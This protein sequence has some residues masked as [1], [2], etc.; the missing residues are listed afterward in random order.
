[1]PIPDQLKEIAEHVSAGHIRRAKVKTLLGYFGSK[2]RGTNVIA[3]VSA[4]LTEL[5]ITTE[6]DWVTADYDLQVRFQPVGCDA[7]TEEPDAAPSDFDLSMVASTTSRPRY[8]AAMRTFTL[9]DRFLR[10]LQ[11]ENLGQVV[12]HGQN[13]RREDRDAYPYY[14]TLEVPPECTQETV[15]GWLQLAAVLAAE[16]SEGDDA[17]PPPVPELPQVVAVQDDQ[18]RGYIAESLEALRADY[19]SQAAELREAVDRRVEEMRFEAIRELAEKLN[20]AK[21]M[22][23]IDDE[24]AAYKARIVIIE[25]E[26]KEA[27]QQ[28]ALLAEQKAELELQAEELDQ[29]DPRDAYPTM[30]AVVALFADLCTK[31][32]VVVAGSANRSAMR[33]ASKRRREILQFLL[34]LREFAIATCGPNRR[35]IRPEDWFEPRGY[36]YAPNDSETTQNQH[37]AERTIIHQGET[38]VMEEHVTLFANSPDCVTVY[39]WTDRDVPRIGVGYVGPHLHTANGR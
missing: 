13:A 18:L 14:L 26:L 4:A 1:M 23:L 28:V 8:R 39:W 27:N 25:A 35:N 32:P 3:T 20:D 2:K 12:V 9:Y 5:G 34:C 36:E 21:F 11:E 10:K 29:Y 38:I 7:A 30:S 19:L 15:E 31:D 16:T 37:A 33:S 6:P 22:K 24:H 17:G